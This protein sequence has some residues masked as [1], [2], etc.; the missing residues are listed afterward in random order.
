[1]IISKFKLNREKKINFLR[2]D[3]VNFMNN[4]NSSNDYKKFLSLVSGGL[5]LKKKTLEHETKIILFD[6]FLN[7]RGKFKNKFNIFFIPVHFFY[8]LIFFFYVKFFQEKHTPASNSKYDILIDNN[9][10]G[11]NIKKFDILKKKKKLLLITSDE[12][13]KKKDD[14]YFFR[15]KKTYLHKN[16]NLRIKD[17]VT[18]IIKTLHLSLKSNNNIFPILIVFLKRYF[19]YH[20]IFFRFTSKYLLQE[21]F[22][23]T[24]AIKDEIFHSYGGR[25]SCV[26]QKNLFQLNGPGM[27]VNADVIFTLGKDSLPNLI[28]FDCK[29]R[30]NQPIGSLF[31][32]RDFYFHPSYKNDK[33]FKKYDLLVFSNTQTSVFNSGYDTYYDEYYKYV[34]WIKKIA[35]KY[36]DLKIGIKHKNSCDN[37]KELEILKE[38]KNVEHVVNNIKYFSDSY[39]LANKAIFLCTWSSTLGYESFGLKKDCFFLDPQDSNLAYLEKNQLND[40]IKIT[41]FTDF[42]EKLLTK[43]KNPSMNL[44][45]DSDMFCLESK[46][47]SERISDFFDKDTKKI[48]H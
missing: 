36:P 25:L 15:Y 26:L 43:I 41:S 44:I 45:K 47:V 32:E 2:D 33:E 27:F 13:L 5:G 7:V 28:N 6:N 34:E 21:R 38:I 9:D 35:L 17:V 31:M 19:K 4:F 16:L 37:Q 48:N 18:I 20:N 12:S 30:K 14:I 42:E 46:H 1:M 23:S 24:S 3:L 22:Y 10:K 8:I 11:S 39:I 40:S 29:I